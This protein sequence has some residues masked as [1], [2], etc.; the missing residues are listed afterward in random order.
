[1]GFL[2]GTPVS[3]NDGINKSTG[4]GGIKNLNQVKKC[5]IE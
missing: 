1:M 4:S 3:K 2:N 5:A